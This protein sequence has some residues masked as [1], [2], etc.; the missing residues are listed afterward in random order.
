M[1][2]LGHF[3]HFAPSYNKPGW[4]TLFTLDECESCGDEAM[5][6]ST[7]H[8]RGPHLKGDALAN[9]LTLTDHLPEELGWCED[10]GGA[11]CGSCHVG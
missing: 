11:V 1:L 9:G 4:F 5:G 3:T 2:R 7:P 10:F 8:L 6:E